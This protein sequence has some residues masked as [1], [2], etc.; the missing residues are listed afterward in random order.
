L[1]SPKALEPEC[2]KPNIIFE[3]GGLKRDGEA[4]DRGGGQSA[5]D[6]RSNPYGSKPFGQSLAKEKYRRGSGKSDA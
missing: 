4:R 1:S 5:R 2:S 3:I 6:P